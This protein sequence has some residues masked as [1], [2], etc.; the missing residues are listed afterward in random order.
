MASTP[1]QPAFKSCF[2]HP[3]YWGLWLIFGIMRCAV[4]LPYPLLMTLGRGIGWCSYHLLKWR[5]HRRVHVVHTNLKLCFP[6]LTEPQRQQLELDTWQSLGMGIMETALAWWAK[7]KVIDQLVTEVKGFEHVKK[8]QQL[9]Q[10]VQLLFAHYST[11]ELGGR[12]IGQRIPLYATS[13]RYHNP[14]SHHMII[15]HR[16]QHLK[17]VLLPKDFKTTVA[18]LKQHATI[19]F[20]LDLDFGHHNTVMSTFMGTPCSTTTTSAKLAKKLNTAVIPMRCYR[21]PHNKGYG[22]AFDAPLKGY[23][24][25]DDASAA[26]LF[27]ELVEI[28]VKQYPEQYYW[29]HQRFKTQADGHSPY[30]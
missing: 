1:A 22:I 9:N 3:K 28:Q 8:A 20:M 14:L 15:K 27:N 25:C 24:E 30:V 4:W 5:K 17:A 12:W 13:K 11:L 16:L 26:R 2:L 10:G 19:A 29:L 21:L 23:G 7:D 18:L 6:H